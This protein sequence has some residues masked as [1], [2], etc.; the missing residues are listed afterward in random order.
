MFLL[1]DKPKSITSHDVIDIIRKITGERKV[2]H[3]GTLDPNA[4]GLLIVGVG[5]ESTKKLGDIAKNTQK[6]Y[7]AEIFLGEERDT[8]DPEGVI[9]QRTKDDRSEFNKT[10]SLSKIQRVLNSFIGEQEQVPP[11]YS[12]IKIGGKKAY[13]MARKGEKLSLGP[14]KIKIHWIKLKKYKFPL[15]EVGVK[16]SSGTYIRALA[17]DIGRKI[18]CGAYLRN[19]RRTQIGEFK[20]E[21][22]VKL[23]KL[24]KDNWRKYV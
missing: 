13:E 15:L 9:L 2:G 20:L 5:R 18:G 1:I 23:D 22:A 3:A 7:G 16:V 8:D 11:V 19:L 24:T 17:R 14:R 10:P 21:N 4:T 6:A 12:A